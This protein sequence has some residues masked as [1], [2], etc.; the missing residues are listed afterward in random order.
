MRLVLATNA[1]EVDLISEARA[2]PHRVEYCRLAY[3]REIVLL[4]PEEP[5]YTCCVPRIDLRLSRQHAGDIR[6]IEPPHLSC[7]GSKGEAT[8]LEELRKFLRKG[9]VGY[10]LCHAAEVST[11]D[12]TDLGVA[13]DTDS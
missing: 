4:Q 8:F 11:V 9:A 12:R 1:T 5:G 3:F 10:L 13:L 2:L 7:Q 6:V